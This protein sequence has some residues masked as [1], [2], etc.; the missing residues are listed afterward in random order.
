MEIKWTHIYKY[1]YIYIY[2][3]THTH[4]YMAFFHTRVIWKSVVM[5][6]QDITQLHLT[7]RKQTKS[8]PLFFLL[9]FLEFLL[10]LISFIS[11]HFLD[12]SVFWF[13]SCYFVGVLHVVTWA[14]QRERN[15]KFIVSQKSTQ[16]TFLCSQVCFFC[17]CFSWMLV[18]VRG[19]ILLFIRHQ[20]QPLGFGINS[21]FLIYF[22]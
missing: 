8:L 4:T 5:V 9:T 14:P 1:I 2:T 18:V 17:F 11:F 21:Q 3:H 22:F 20:P 7:Q 19:V 15:D 6:T 10:F 12:L 16:I 13:S